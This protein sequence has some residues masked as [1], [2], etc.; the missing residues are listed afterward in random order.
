M[1]VR[2][3]QFRVAAS[4]RLIR[5]SAKSHHR[6]L[7]CCG[8]GPSA[9]CGSRLRRALGW[10]VRARPDAGHRRQRHGRQAMRFGVAWTTQEA[11]TVDYT[12]IADFLINSSGGSVKSRKTGV[13]H[14]RVW[15]LRC[16][17]LDLGG[18]ITSQKRA[19]AIFATSRTRPASNLRERRA[20][21][22]FRHG[23]RST[24]PATEASSRRPTNPGLHR[25]PPCRWA[26][27]VRC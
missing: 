2:R 3:G 15:V 4:A 26:W 23:R 5:A 1:A 16:G 27:R 21:A 12:P 19:V 11:S 9:G 24:P 10:P 7:T 17:G 20:A 25:T 8:S 18:G 13:G 6:D 22:P 14:R